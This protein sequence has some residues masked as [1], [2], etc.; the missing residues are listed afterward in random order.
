MVTHF[1]WTFITNTHRKDISV[2]LEV[3]TVEL[4]TYLIPYNPDDQ[5]C[6][7]TK[8]RWDESWDGRDLMAGNNFVQFPLLHIYEI[9][10]KISNIT[11]VIIKLNPETSLVS[12]W[13]AQLRDLLKILPL[14]LKHWITSYQFWM[15]GP[16]ECVWATHH[17]LC[18]V[19]RNN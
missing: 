4:H 7:F 16:N 11:V 13:F 17:Q 9:L 15:L 19:R 3:R 1:N 18:V 8:C 14:H 5:L 2:A 10:G 6:L 12:L